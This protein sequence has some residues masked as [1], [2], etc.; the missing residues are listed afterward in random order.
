M[1]KKEIDFPL[2]RIL[3]IKTQSLRL[4][5]ILTAFDGIFTDITPLSQILFK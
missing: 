2:E 1:K 3:M 5:C 4:N